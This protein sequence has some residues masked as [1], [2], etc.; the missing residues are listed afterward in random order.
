MIKKIKPVFEDERGAI[1]DILDDENILHIGLITAK[2]GAVRGN[3][4]HKKAKQFNHILSGKMELKITDIDTGKVI[5]HT[6]E[7]NDFISIPAGV[8]HTLIA[9]E[10]SEFIDLNT[11]SRSEDGYEQDTIRLNDD[12]RI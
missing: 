11:E 12:T 3:H 1:Y 10:D 8:G 7:K 6:L 9:L 2:K 4:Y 5:K